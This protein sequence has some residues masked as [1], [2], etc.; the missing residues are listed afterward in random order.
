MLKRRECERKFAEIEDRLKHINDRVGFQLEYRDHL[1][2]LR[3]SYQIE[4]AKALSRKEPGTWQTELYPNPKV[5]GYDV[6]NKQRLR[7]FFEE[8]FRNF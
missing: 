2:R 6:E 8:N 4:Y 1:L 7:G 5:D 3:R